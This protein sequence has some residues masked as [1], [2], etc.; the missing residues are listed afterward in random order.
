MPYYEEGKKAWELHGENADFVKDDNIQVDQPRLLLISS[1]NVTIKAETGLYILKDR[2]CNLEDNV[3]G[4]GTNLSFTTEKIRLHFKDSLLVFPE[5]F[6]V[7]LEGM[8]LEAAK[9]QLVIESGKLT[10]EG[11]TLLTI[12]NSTSSIAASR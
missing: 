7:D 8:W 9:G 3:K 11:N 5:N 4:K 2:I 6:Q 10:C 12:D 1:G